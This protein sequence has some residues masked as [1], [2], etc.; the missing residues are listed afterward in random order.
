MNRLKG[1]SALITGGRQGIGRSIVDLF[2]QEGATVITCGRGQRPSDLDSSVLWVTADVSRSA[3]ITALKNTVEFKLGKLSILVNN[4]GIQLEK[5]VLHTSDAD[6][7]TLMGV[8]C[9]GV[10]L[11]CRELIPIMEKSGSI[12]NISSISATTADYGLGLYNASKAFVQGLTR[13]IAVDHGDLIRCN[14]INPGWIMTEMAD[15]AFAV[16][17]N[18]KAAKTDAL[19]RH[20]VGRFGQPQD[21]AKLAVWLASNDSTFATGQCYTLDGGLT[22]ASPLNPGFF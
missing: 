15:A 20:P 13:S 14:A 11:C 3:D 21:V 16:A 12:I 4:A 1:K 17:E 6:W 9:K 18:P 5:S 10:F 2:V 7:E 22:A 19:K 8:N